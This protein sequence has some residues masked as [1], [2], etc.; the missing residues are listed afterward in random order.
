[1]R[2]VGKFVFVLLLA[3]LCRAQ[4][5]SVTLSVVD[6]GGQSWNNGTWSVQLVSPPGVPCCNYVIAGTSTP[7]PNQQQ[8]GTLGA[9][10]TASLT[11]TPVTSIAPSGTQWSFTGCSQAAPAPC[12]TKSFTVS[13][14]S[15]SVSLT[16]PAIQINLT[17]PQLRYAAYSD[18]EV[19]GGALGQMYWNLTDST[20]HICTSVVVSC[21]FTSLSFTGGLPIA[22]AQ[23]GDTL[24]FN[25][26][27]DNAFDAVNYAQPI[28][29]IYSVQGG[30]PV[31]T[32]SMTTGLAVLGSH[33]SIIATAT[34]GTG[35]QYASS[36]LASTS[37]VIG[38]ITGQSGNNS[39]TGMLAFY[40]W[41][42]KIKIG[43]LTNVRYWMGLGCWNSTG[44]GNNG[45]GILGTTAYAADTPNKTTLGFRF[46]AGTDTHW[47]AVAAVAGGSQTTVDTG[48]TPDTTNI[49]IYEMTTNPA[50]T[51]VF[52]FIDNILVAT[53][54]TNLPNPASGGDSW[55]DMFWTGDNKNSATSVS[56]I[57]YYM[58]LSHK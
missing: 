6:A 31:A 5:T 46:S 9:A 20:F 37:T 48:V 28:S 36:A 40:R 13:G 58:Q 8:S 21:V 3:T 57:Q 26:R 24:R 7:V 15:Q 54:T 18:S 50:G 51:S 16:P 4:T 14:A 42:L 25:V 43:N 11:V 41:T 45:V 35:D 47:Q 29:Y 55:G 49:H 33:T 38:L 17:Q 22:S 12:F 1:M 44:A 32:G 39:V 52:Y 30:Q 10:G 34:D 56:A 53:I 2:S 27:G 19:V 23:L